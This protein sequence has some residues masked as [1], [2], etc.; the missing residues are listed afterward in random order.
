MWF[1][2]LIRQFVNKTVLEDNHDY[3]TKENLHLSEVL[4]SFLAL[5]SLFDVKNY[6]RFAI[7]VFGVKGHDLKNMIFSK[8]KLGQT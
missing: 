5:T 8:S 4:S 6:D 1:E 7:I 2:L 3:E